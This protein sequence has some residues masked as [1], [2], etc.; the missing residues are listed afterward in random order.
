MTDPLLTRILVPLDGS[1]HAEA[2]LSQLRRILPPHDCHLTLL[3]TLPFAPWTSEEE[4]AR[5]LRRVAFQ[6]T[7]DGYPS[8]PMLRQGAPAETILETAMTERVSMIALTTHG[9]SGTARWVFG[10][11]AERILQASPLPVLVAR[12]FPPTQCRGKLESRPMRNFLVPLDGSLQS[13]GALE[14][15]LNL[16]RP[17][18]AHVTLLQVSEPSP[19]DGRWDPPD[20]TLKDADQ[21]LRAACIPSRIEHRKGEAAE[22]ILKTAEEEGIDLIAMTTHGRSGPS[23]WIYGSVAAKVL[24][25]AAVP[26]LVVRH[27]V[28]PGKFTPRAGIPRAQE[29]TSGQTAHGTGLAPLRP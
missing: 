24:R 27:A 13:L 22:G 4:A 2:I 29:A 20:E 3:Q 8:T 17:V 16:A 7:N 10:S 1:I 9:R 19:V 11:V 28:P 15:V 6:L 21:F 23:R 14:P 18:D 5:Y 26:L 12:S 25:G